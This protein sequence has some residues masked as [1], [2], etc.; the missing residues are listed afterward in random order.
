MV[1]ESNFFF[2]HT[3]DW[4]L[5]GTEIVAILFTALHKGRLFTLSVILQ[6][7]VFVKFN[8][9]EMENFINKLDCGAMVTSDGAE[10][11]E[12]P[13]NFRSD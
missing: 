6:F 3:N 7:T 11:I 5:I 13:E 10:I 1:P 2:C 9:E 8:V 4:I 12:T